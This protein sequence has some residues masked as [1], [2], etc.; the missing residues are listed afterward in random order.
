M[1]SSLGTGFMAVF[2]ASGSVVLLAM[3]VHKRLLSNFMKQMEFEFKN[4][5]VGVK[6]E[7]KKKVRFADEETVADQRS[8]GKKHMSRPAAAAGAAARY[9]N[10]ENLE[11]MPQNW[12]VMYKGILQCRNLRGYN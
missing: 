5:T 1:D 9:N 10:N 8:C 7:P 6:D 11:G 4:S 12:Q 3:Q 2:A